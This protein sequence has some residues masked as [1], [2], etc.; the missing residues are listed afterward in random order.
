VRDKQ[1]KENI[2]PE[3]SKAS[4]S[5]GITSPHSRGVQSSTDGAPHSRL[6]NKNNA[7]S[8]VDSVGN[9]Y[10]DTVQLNN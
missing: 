8:V 5:T 7:Y 9:A 3:F 10:N 1:S 4:K 2:Q 6:N